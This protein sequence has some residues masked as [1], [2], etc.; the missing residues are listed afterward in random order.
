MEGMND[1]HTGFAGGAAGLC[2]RLAVVPAAAA[3][4]CSI[5]TAE[6]QEDEG[7]PV[8]TASACAVDR[9]D[10][11]LSL[12][13][14]DGR[15]WLRYDLSLG[16]EA[17]VDPDEVADVVFTFG[18][19]RETLSMRYEDMD[20]RHAADVTVGNPLVGLLKS[21]SMLSIGDAAGSYP[22]QRLR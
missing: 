16:A 14:F 18:E 3:E 2:R 19:V 10:A 4:A 22:S 21:G 17:A 1:P 11:Y 8:L 13:C 7:G 20:G 9:P 5:W 6:M 15:V 12:T